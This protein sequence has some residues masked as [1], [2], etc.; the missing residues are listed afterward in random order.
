MAIDLHTHSVYS[1]GSDSPDEIVRRAKALGLHAV[2]LT[3]HDTTAG[4]T[5]FMEAGARKGLL[6]IPG[7][8]L[9]CEYKGRDVH[10]LGYRIRYGE[11]SLED[12]LKAVR[13]ERE[14]RNQRMLQKLSELG[15][16]LTYEEVCE[17]SHG[18]IVSRV[19]F[20]LALWK[21][22]YVESKNEAF[23]RL[24]G[25]GGPAYL[26]R[27]CMTVAEGV[28]TICASGGIA[29]L[30][31]PMQYQLEEAELE[32]LLRHMKECGATGVEVIHSR[33]PKE[34]TGRLIQMACRLGLSC[35]GGSD[36]H[37]INKTNVFLGEGYDGAR[38][39]DA[40]L[41][42]LH[43]EEYISISPER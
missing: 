13:A 27:H 3:D 4:L 43:L 41:A 37:G 12:K 39:P 42:A 31:H 30:A 34:D 21:K 9:S 11:A 20:A 18:A 10:V 2:A 16:P 32:R 6:T 28:Q 29:V 19:H 24:I 1:D 14:E 40:Y 23:D 15:Y 7:I 5:E 36:Y 25:N 22:G 26:P 35:T 33:C 38:I 17:Q 8:E